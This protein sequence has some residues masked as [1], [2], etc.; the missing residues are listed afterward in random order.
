[1]TLPHLKLWPSTYE[2]ASQLGNH[3]SDLYKFFEI[4]TCL[5]LEL[6]PATFHG[7]TGSSSQAA[8]VDLMLSRSS[9]T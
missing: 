9:N 6:S 5:P 8:V 3:S 1:M 7:T 2:D 4:M